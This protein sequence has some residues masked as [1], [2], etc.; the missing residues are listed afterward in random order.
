MPLRIL[1]VVNEA[2]F[3]LSH[4]LPLACAAR[5][6]GYDVHVATPGSDDVRRIRSEGF[7]HHAFPLDRKGINPLRDIRSIGA[8]ARIFAKARPDLIHTVT[9]KP[10]LYG[11]IAARLVGV[12]AVVSAISGLGYVFVGNGLPLRIVRAIVKTGYRFALKRERA[13]VIVQ[14]QED[15][16]LITQDIGVNSDSVVLIPGSGV[17]LDQFRPSREPDGLPVIMLA[18][19]MLWDKGVGEFVAAA[20]RL[21]DEGI[22][23]RFVLVGDTDS[24]NPAAVPTDRLVAWSD[25]GIVE[26]WGRREDMAQV[27]AQAHVVCL[28]SY[29]REGVPKILLEAA[30]S[31]RPII[32]TDTP[33]CRDAVADGSS[34]ILV[35]SR[36]VTGLAN[37]VRRLIENPSL[38]LTMALQGRKMAEA[39]FDVARVIDQTMDI[40]RSLIGPADADQDPLTV[41]GS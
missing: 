11:G 26:W 4:R 25:A 19:R 30:A 8:L 37:A 6:L 2:S 14:N 13:C 22:S 16:A 5:A 23:A 32:T 31:G 15:R 39:R 12:P 27:L 9:I 7:M 29:Y 10:V 35:R 34:G 20:K 41:R 1:F 38:R 24:G 18:S 28:P 3:F 33:G 21:R 36:D 17:N 40:Y